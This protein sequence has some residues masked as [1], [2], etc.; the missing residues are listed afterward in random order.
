MYAKYL[1]YEP[2]GRCW[3]IADVPLSDTSSQPG[4]CA[5]WTVLN[6]SKKALSESVKNR[7]VS[8]K[9]MRLLMAYMTSRSLCTAAQR[10]WLPLGKLRSEE[11]TVWI[12]GIRIFVET[13]PVLMVFVSQTIIVIYWH[14]SSQPIEYGWE[15]KD[16]RSKQKTVVTRIR[17]TDR[18][19]QSFDEL[20]FKDVNILFSCRS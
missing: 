8:S 20:M 16:T 5:V 18:Q 3:L 15:E 13:A 7:R 1:A 11:D 10:P 12:N 19:T 6:A 9:P 2:D 4:E 14:L 17:L